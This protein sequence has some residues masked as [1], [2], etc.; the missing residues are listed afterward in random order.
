MSRLAVLSLKNRALIA[1]I[2]IC[3]A[4][5]G[6]LSLTTLKQELIPA[7]ELPQLLVM[8]T[9]PGASPEVVENDVSTPIET[10]IQGVAGLDGTSATSTTN[11]SIVQASFAY[12]TDLATAEQKMQQAI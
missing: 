3:A 6:G 9:Y 12:G 11:S 8:T 4:I 1:L 10:A 7:I 2:T 5:F